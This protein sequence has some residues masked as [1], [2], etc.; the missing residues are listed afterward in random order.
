VRLNDEALRNAQ[1]RACRAEWFCKGFVGQ[2]GA[3]FYT[4]LIEKVPVIGNT[5]QQSPSV[6][7]FEDALDKAVE[8][9]E[10]LPIHVGHHHPV[11]WQTPNQRPTHVKYIA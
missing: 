11:K 2:R 3:S 9:V 7:R 4:P 6:N 1:E 5:W 8:L 10:I